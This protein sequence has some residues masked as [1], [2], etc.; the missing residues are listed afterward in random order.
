MIEFLFMGLGIEKLRPSYFIVKKILRKK[1][2]SHVLLNNFFPTLSL[3]ILD[4]AKQQNS[5]ILLWLHN[6]RH[7]CANGLLFNG[8]GQNCHQCLE[9]T[10]WKAFFYNCYHSW[11]QSFLYGLT[12]RNQR[13][14]KKILQHTDHVVAPSQYTMNHFKKMQQWLKETKTPQESVIYFPLVPQ[15]VE[16][17]PLKKLQTPFY[18]FIGRLSYEKGA[19]LFLKQAQKFPNKNFV[20]AGDGPM[21]NELKSMNTP[22][23]AFLGRVD[24]AEKNW[25][26]KNTEAILMTS[27]VGENSPMVIYESHSY[28]TPVVYPQDGGAQEVMK[29]LKRSGCSIDE[30]QGQSFLKAAVTQVSDQFLTELSQLFK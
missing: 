9:K 26:F 30:F 13:I 12:Y 1:Q 16:T 17:A 3:S 27:R 20:L 5:K 2:Y 8:R 10:S 29:R 19:D 11:A 25:L 22:N 24:L 6:A 14:S 7:S 21:E 23:V 15:S 4:T 18:L 28:R